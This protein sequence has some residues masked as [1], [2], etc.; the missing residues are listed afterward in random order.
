MDT[1]NDIWKQVLSICKEEVSDVMYNMW[2]APLEFINFEN[3]TVVFTVNAEFRKNIILTKFS[4]ILKRAF[5]SVIGFEVEI[6]VIVNEAANVK[7]KKNEINTEKEDGEKEERAA[8]PVKDSLSSYTFDNFIVGKSNFFSYEV[9][10]RVAANPGNENPFL[11]Y[12]NSGLGKTHLLFAIYNELKRKNPNSVVIYTTSSNF[13]SEFINCLESKTTKSFQNKYRNVDALLI[14]DIQM[15]RSGERTQEEF[16][17]TFNALY[18][19]GKQIVLT[20]DVPPKE[21]LGFDERLRTRFEMGIITDVTAPD[22]ET[23]KAII[24][25]KCNFYGIT[26]SDAA[27]DLIATKITSNIRQI[28][29]TVNKIEAIRK[30]YGSMP[31]YEQIQAIVNDVVHDSV[32]VDTIAEKVFSTVSEAFGVTVD[33]I[34]SNQRAQKIT[35]ARNVSMYVLRSVIQGITL[36]EIGDFFGKNHATVSHSLNLVTDAMEKDS[37]F[38]NTV[39]NIIRQVKE[40]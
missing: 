28:E 12:G 7:D 16:F 34:K 31:T 21:M 5:M 9:A 25:R 38:K 24:K 37:I 13:M 6:D 3:D 17:N 18:Q 14:D 26:L 40:K 15:M 1:L 20:A 39:N 35:K 11:I 10:K 2:L 22:V 33:E 4:D 19:A 32:P 27:T 30:V 36:Q 23:R 8:E 29:G